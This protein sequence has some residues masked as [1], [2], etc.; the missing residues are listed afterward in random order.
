MINNDFGVTA[1]MKLALRTFEFHSRKTG[2]TT[3]LIEAAREGDIIITSSQQHKRVI[4]G[5]LRE[6]E[7]ESLA[8]TGRRPAE[9]VSVFV[10]DPKRDIR[11]LP[12]VIPA[13]AIT[14]RILYDHEFIREYWEARFDDI[15]S[16]LTEVAERMGRETPPP[17][18][19]QKQDSMEAFGRM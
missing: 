7:S 6:K 16:D 1:A 3:T 5:A 11:A 4:E 10:V 12:N 2:R 18:R 15:G 13:K 17:M 9:K 8:T 19:H 14:G